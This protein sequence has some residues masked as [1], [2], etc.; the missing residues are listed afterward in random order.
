MPTPDGTECFIL[1]LPDELLI[2]VLNDA[3]L[4]F[5]NSWDRDPERE[6]V[7]RKT[8]RDL[9][10]VCRRFNA[11]ARPLLY[12][13]AVLNS[14]DF[15]FTSD[16]MHR[17]M[18]ENPHMRSLCRSIVLNVWEWQSCFENSGET[19]DGVFEI[20][21]ELFSWWA[22]ARSV[23]IEGF[24]P[25]IPFNSKG[26]ALVQT[27]CQSMPRLKELFVGMEGPFHLCKAIET[28]HSPSLNVLTLK[29]Y[30]Y[31]PETDSW[32]VD[33]KVRTSLCF[34]QSQLH[35]IGKCGFVDATVATSIITHHFSHHQHHQHQ[36]V[37]FG[38]SHPMAS[39]AG[40]ICPGRVVRE[41]PWR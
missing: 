32:T 4:E 5:R 39:T 35:G 41:R 20:I 40:K 12:E 23:Y 17:T 8:A 10:L 6:A 13:T 30:P 33:P 9:P 34:L 38:T 19:D 27:A 24:P 26:W 37:G 25:G 29:S 11:L 36:P 22:S 28:I 14:V 3:T 7:A 18:Q 16:L 31:E 1:R 15:I 2:W 21:H